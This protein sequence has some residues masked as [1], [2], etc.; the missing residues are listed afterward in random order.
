MTPDRFREGWPSTAEELIAV[1]RELAVARPPAWRPPPGPLAIAGCWICFPRGEQGAGARGQRAWAAA[2]LLRGRRS[3]RAATVAGEAG[4]PYEPGLLALREGALLERAVRALAQRP[5][6]LLVDATGRDHPRRAGLAL[7][8]G[9][10]L[11]LPSIGV[12]NRPLLASAPDPGGERG[13]RTALTL[14]GEPVGW[15]LRTR[16]GARPLAVH[17]AWR[18][19]LDSAVEVVLA[20]GRGKRAPEPLRRARRLAREARASAP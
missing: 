3:I 16:T 7:H 9:A 10:I 15:W 5:D 8:L 14:E 18:T 12:T 17:P 4:A 6:V 11:D 20:A 1:Q 19:D 13:A 2:A